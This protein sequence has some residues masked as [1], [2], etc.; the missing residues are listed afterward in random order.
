MII[1]NAIAQDIVQLIEL[2]KPKTADYRNKFRENQIQ[3]LEEMEEKK[4]IYLIAEEGTQVIGHV[5]IKFYG[6]Q[7][8]PEYPNMQDLYVEK[9]KRGKGVGT[10]L[11]YAAEHVA[12]KNG[13]SKISLAVNP[14]MNQKAESLYK[15]L[16]YRKTNTQPY[17]DGVYDGVE[18]WCIDMIKKLI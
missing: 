9:G 6:S 18:D 5:F 1:R 14:T 4:A 11:I 7:T 15:K 17:I 10:Q 2:K 16:G 12:K 8:E 3:R 13:Y